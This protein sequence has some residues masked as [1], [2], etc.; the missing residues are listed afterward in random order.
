MSDFNMYRDCLI[1]LVVKFPGLVN[2]EHAVDSVK[3]VEELRSKIGA[4]NSPEIRA[5]VTPRRVHGIVKFIERGR[6]LNIAVGDELVYWI[7]PWDR[8]LTCREGQSVEVE[9]KR[10]SF[11]RNEVSAM[12]SQVDEPI[13]QKEVV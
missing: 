2:E 12:L 7:K 13:R 8:V 6:I 10:S 5:A 3:L 11:G 4:L 9:I 1:E